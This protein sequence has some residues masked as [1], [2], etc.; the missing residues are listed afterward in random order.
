[1]SRTKYIYTTKRVDG[2]VVRTYVGK[3][4]SVAGRLYELQQQH[5]RNSRQALQELSQEWEQFYGETVDLSQL[6]RVAM[7][8]R[9]YTQ[10]KQRHWIKCG[11]NREQRQ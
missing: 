6:E 11:T 3:R 2:R 4:G 10:T 8:E 5:R 9:G 7:R 1:M